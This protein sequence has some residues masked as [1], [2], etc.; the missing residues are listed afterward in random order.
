MMEKLSSYTCYCV[1]FAFVLLVLNDY[2]SAQEEAYRKRWQPQGRFGKRTLYDEGFKR[3]WRPQGRFGKRTL[4]DL[5]AESHVLNEERISGGDI[6][7]HS[8]KTG[9]ALMN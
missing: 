8:G 4:G 1:I 7:P 9:K 3:G 5:D 2:S 6:L